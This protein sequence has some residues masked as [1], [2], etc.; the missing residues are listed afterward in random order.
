MKGIFIAILILLL[1]VRYNARAQSPTLNIIPLN[2]DIEVTL[3]GCDKTTLYCYHL[4]GFKYNDGVE[5]VIGEFIV[6][7]DKDT[8]QNKEVVNL[9]LC[10]VTEFS[11]MNGPGKCRPIPTNVG[12]Q[13]EYRDGRE[14][15]FL[16]FDP[17]GPEPVF[18]PC[19]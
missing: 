6:F 18:I 17:S 1:T 15:L 14:P 19:K 7:R 10:R 13:L 12:I 2:E 9:K 16:N 3:L 8:F 5:D 4:Y 11:I